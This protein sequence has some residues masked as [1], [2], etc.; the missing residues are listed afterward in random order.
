MHWNGAGGKRLLRAAMNDLLPKEVLAHRKQGFSIPLHKW[1]TPEYFRLAKDLLNDTAV[2]RRGIFNP[3]AVQNVLDRCCNREMSFKA[4]ESDY[5][6]SHK[7]LMLVSF[8][9]W[10]RFYMDDLVAQPSQA[11]R[12]AAFER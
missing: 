6:V 1:T 5:R 10:C 3:A 7:L 12:W 4:L 2:R 11:I 9:L 8:E